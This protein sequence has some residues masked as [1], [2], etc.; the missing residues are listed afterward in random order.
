MY[1]KW[2]EFVNCFQSRSCCVGSIFVTPFCLPIR[3]MSM[4][5]SLSRI[6][7]LC[8]LLWMW[9]NI[10]VCIMGIWMVLSMWVGMYRY[11]RKYV[12]RRWLLILIISRYGNM[13]SVVGILVILLG[14]KYS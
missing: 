5:K 2:S 6:M 3:A 9:L 14:N 10:V 8:G 11:I 13:S 7:L 12:V 4:L 1:V